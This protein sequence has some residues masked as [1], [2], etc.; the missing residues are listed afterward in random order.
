MERNL[1]RLQSAECSVSGKELDRDSSPDDT[2]ELQVLTHTTR[3]MRNLLVLDKGQIVGSKQQWATTN[4]V[5]IGD[6]FSVDPRQCL[7]P[8]T[9]QPG[10]IDISQK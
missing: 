3:Q 5:I 6:A 2:I 9:F 10:Q 7:H 8:H 1:S 4:G